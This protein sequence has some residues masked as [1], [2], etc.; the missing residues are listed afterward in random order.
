MSKK[1]NTRKD[2]LYRERT[3]G[4][5]HIPSKEENARNQKSK[6]SELIASQRDVLQVIYDYDIEAVE[7]EAVAAL[8]DLISHMSK[9]IG[10]M[11]Q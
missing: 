8:S 10:V 4:F 1:L 6:V 3:K 9:V 7:G 5:L 2:Y 11:K